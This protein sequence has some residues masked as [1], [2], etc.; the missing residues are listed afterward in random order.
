MTLT[1]HDAL[2]AASGVTVRFGGLV[3]LREV[4][5]TVHQNTV[6]G[7]IGPNGAGKTTLFNVLCGFVRAQSGT[8]A[9]DGTPL[10]TLRPDRLARLGI[11]RT[12]QGLGLFRGL[13]VLENVMTGADH[14]ARAGVLGVLLGL[15][16]SASDEREIRDRAMTTLAELGIADAASAYPGTLPYGMQKQVALA[17]ALAGRPRLLMLDEPASGL[18]AR[19]MDGLVEHIDALRER[20]AVVLVEHHMDVVM[21]VCDRIEVLN[22]GEVIATGPPAQIQADPKVAEAYLG[23][24]AHDG[25]PA[26]A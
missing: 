18:S 14:H 19:E 8:V 24:P 12:L 5:L 26:D 1:H 7:V 6:V 4:D 21:R 13:T 11:A 17:R 10:R 16:R 23:D 22:F 20:M 3:A 9:W 25:E 15:R 2:L